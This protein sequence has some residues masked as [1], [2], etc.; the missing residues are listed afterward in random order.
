MRKIECARV[1]VRVCEHS[2]RVR[3]KPA[4]GEEL[5]LITTQRQRF[6]FVSDTDTQQT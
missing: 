3:D 1:C 5:G 4:R 2:N 6:S